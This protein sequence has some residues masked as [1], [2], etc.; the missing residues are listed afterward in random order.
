M[1]VPRKKK[2]EFSKLLRN[3]VSALSEKGLKDFL[4]SNVSA[5]N[6]TLCRGQHIVRELRVEWTCFKT[7]LIIFNVLD[8]DIRK[9]CL[10][11]FTRI[12][13]FYIY[14]FLAALSFVLAGSAIIAKRVYTSSLHKQ[15]PVAIWR[16]TTYN[17]AIWRHLSPYWAQIYSFL[18]PSCSL[19]RKVLLQL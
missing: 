9:K 5:D 10:P 7:Y 15:H 13:M 16:L 19:S 14:F 2:H 4:I 11:V 17:C 8:W 1:Y 3:S 6:I 18:V 12:V